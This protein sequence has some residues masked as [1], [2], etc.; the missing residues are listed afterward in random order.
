MSLLVVGISHRSADLALLERVALTHTVPN[1]VRVVLDQ[2]EHLD[3]DDPE[4]DK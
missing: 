3:D 2:L 4:E 1:D